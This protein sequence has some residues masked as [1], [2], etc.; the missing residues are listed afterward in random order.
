VAEEATPAAPEP[1][2]YGSQAGVYER[3]EVKVPDIGEFSDVPVIEVHVAA[4]DTVAAEDPLITLESDKATMD[5]PAPAGGTV[6][7]VRVAVGDTVSEGDVI[8]DLETGQEA[9]DSREQPPSGSATLPLRGTSQG[10]VG[11]PR[12]GFG[13]ASRRRRSR[14]RG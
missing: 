13:H 7:G 9:V 1:A 14:A 2:S 3:L 10:E 12:V 5:V 4:G 11:F 6:A 8:L